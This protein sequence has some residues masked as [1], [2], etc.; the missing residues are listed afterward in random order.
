MQYI[1]RMG[2][3]RVGPVRADSVA[4]RGNIGAAMSYSAKW[5]QFL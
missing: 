2:E 3:I 5:I 4:S 1:P